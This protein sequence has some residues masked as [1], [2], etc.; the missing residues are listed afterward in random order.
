METIVLGFDGSTSSTAAL[1][2][3]ADRAARRPASV[4]IIMIGGTILEAGAGRET[5]LEDAERRVRDRAAGTEVAS[6]RFTG[7]MPD[8]LL[9]RARTADLLVVGSHRGHPLWAALSRWMP[10]RVASRS[11]I[12]VVVVP[13]DAE[14][15]TGKV[16]VGV[17]DDDSSLPAID[18]AA[19]EAAASASPLVL[20]HSWQMPIPQMEGSVALLASPIE[21]RAGHRRMLRAAELRVQEAHP[22]V[23]IVQVLEQS[24]PV[25]ALLH[26]SRGADLIVIGTH[27]RGFLAGALLGSTGRDLLSQSRIPVCVV[28]GEVS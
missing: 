4:E 22:D 18:F 17:D 2:W 19:N 10:Q 5:R 11:A 13:E 7:T 16:V 26:A 14:T 25:S 28:P 6:H 12:P 8:A 23:P 21:A 1:E 9:E 15:T 24:N 27:H 3:V 20:V